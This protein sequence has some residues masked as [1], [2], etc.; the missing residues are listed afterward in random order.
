MCIAA[1]NMHYYWLI[2]EADVQKF[3]SYCE[4]VSASSLPTTHTPCLCRIARLSLLR[5]GDPVPTV[6]GILCGAQCGVPFQKVG[7]AFVTP[8]NKELKARGFCEA[9]WKHVLS[10]VGLPAYVTGERDSRITVSESRKLFRYI[11]VQIKLSVAYR[12]QTDGQTERFDRTCFVPM[13]TSITLIGISTSLHIFMC[14]ITLSIPRQGLL[15]TVCSLGGAPEIS[16]LRSR[17]WAHGC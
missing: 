14:T 9:L 5:L 10:W 1:I 16:E 2:L 13:L 8:C 7:I 15:P 17:Q 12:P 6:R 4:I 3:I 11:V